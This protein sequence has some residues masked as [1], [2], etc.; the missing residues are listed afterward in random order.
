MPDGLPSILE[1]LRVLINILDPNDR[2]H[3]DSTRLT[4]LGILN[5]ALDVSG[6]RIA[7]FP[8]LSNLIQD[9]GCKYLFQ[10]ARSDN[11]YV[12]YSSLRVIST[13]LDSLRSGL[14]LQRELFFAFTIDRLVPT[15]AS[16]AQIIAAQK[17]GLLGSPRP[18]TPVSM[19]PTPVLAS[20]KGDDVVA[21]TKPPVVPARGE[22]RELMLETLNDIA[23]HPSFMVDLYCNYDCDV[24]C[25][26]LFDKLID[27]L[28]KVTPNIS[29][30]V[31]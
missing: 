27:F 7:E 20:E 3:T 22:A 16:M 1:L 19:P 8:S 17:K 2:L 25:E 28:T 12:L 30:F 18:G 21:P 11:A 13:I 24:N 10:L 31:Q 29:R 14:K 6:P 26:D 4:S 9:H 15:V 23:R 5:A